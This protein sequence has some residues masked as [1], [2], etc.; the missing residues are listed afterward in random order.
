MT[1]TYRNSLLATLSPD[2]SP[3]P[4]TVAQQHSVGSCHGHGTEQAPPRKVIPRSTPPRSIASP[5]A[6]WARAISRSGRTARQAP[7][8]PAVNFDYAT[9]ERRHFGPED[10]LGRRGPGPVE[11]ASGLAD[12]P[13]RTLANPVEHEARDS[14]RDEEREEALALVGCRPADMSTR[15][16]AEMAAKVVAIRPKPSA[17]TPIPR[18][19]R[20]S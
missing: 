6:S 11:G 8:V 7:L 1:T 16:S 14:R 20:R 19:G 18:S 10:L 2:S 9:F 15:V 12:G 17:L 13:V 5:R 4:T 3:S